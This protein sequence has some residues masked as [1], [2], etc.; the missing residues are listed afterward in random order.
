MQDGLV[1]VAAVLL[2]V[3]MG[4]SG[5][6][7]FRTPRWRTLWLAVPA[8][9]LAFVNFSG[10]ITS[11]PGRIGT[12]ALVSFVV[13][14][15]EEAW[16]RGVFLRALLPRYGPLGAAALLS[17]FFGLAHSLNLLSGQDMAVTA[18][19][20]VG[21]ML[22]AFVF[23]GIR[24]RTG[25]LWPVILIHAVFDFMSWIGRE[26]LVETTA[27][28]LSQEYVIQMLILS[29]VLFGYGLLLLRGARWPAGG[30]RARADVVP[31]RA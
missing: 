6:V 16:W 24:L 17:L 23:T 18:M 20:I 28:Q 8:L 9:I 10:E 21:A 11:G 13:S 12:L 15:Q 29:L 3:A 14:F 27:P 2:I 30:H 19:Q 7:G 4:W 1:S 5:E 25:S 26:S 22:I 31:V